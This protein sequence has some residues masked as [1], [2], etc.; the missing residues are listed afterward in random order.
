MKQLEDYV[1]DG[2]EV[3]LTLSPSEEGITYSTWT[4]D[5]TDK[6]MLALVGTGKSMKSMLKD[7]QE[8]EAEIYPKLSKGK[9]SNEAFR[10]YKP[11]IQWDSGLPVHFF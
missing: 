11:I 9:Q 1:K 6:E 2:W 10:K 4:Y 7:L 8:C 5:H 3:Q